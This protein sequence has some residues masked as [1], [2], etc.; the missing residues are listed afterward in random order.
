MSSLY[1][2]LMPRTVPLIQLENVTTA[3][4]TAIGHHGPTQTTTTISP[5]RS[6][7]EYTAI[8]DV[9]NI[10]GEL[11]QNA[12]NLYGNFSDDSSGKHFNNQAIDNRTVDDDKDLLKRDHVFDRTDVRVIFIT[13]YTLVFCFCFFGEYLAGVFICSV[14]GGGGGG[15]RTTYIAWSRIGGASKERYF[16]G[17]RLLTPPLLQWGGGGVRWECIRKM[18]MT[19]ID[20]LSSKM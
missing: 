16:E 7:F 3:L 14:L 4:H 10:T 2:A 11:Y 13:M 20:F 18:M 8:D 9:F 15:R 12:T 6:L 5:M 17:K 19:E 1:H